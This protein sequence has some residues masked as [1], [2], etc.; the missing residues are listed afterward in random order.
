VSLKESHNA[1]PYEIVYW[2]VLSFFV[3]LLFLQIKDTIIPSCFEIFV[4][5][6]IYLF[7][8]FVFSSCPNHVFHNPNL[9]IHFSISFQEFLKCPI[10][11]RFECVPSFWLI[12]SLI[13]IFLIL[14]LVAS[15]RLR[16]WHIITIKM[17]SIN[18][19]KY[20]YRDVINMCSFD[21]VFECNWKCTCKTMTKIYAHGTW[22][23]VRKK[24]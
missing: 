19:F 4:D 8:N 9:D 23:I 17:Y 24:K 1:H 20:I 5:Q 6:F 2:E 14:T 12:I 13:P 21:S 3:L 15:P 10:W 7:M 18:M 22:I 11:I 16:L